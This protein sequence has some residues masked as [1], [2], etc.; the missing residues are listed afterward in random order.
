MDILDDDLIRLWKAL[1]NHDVRYMMVGGFAAI[2]HGT[3]RITQDAD[4]WI[5]DTLQNRQ[6]FRKAL[7]AADVGDYE[8]LETMDFVPGFTTIYLNQYIE[9]DLFTDL[10]FFTSKRFDECYSN[11]ETAMIENIPVK[12]LSLQHLIEE[13][14][15]ADRPKDLLD[16]EELE[17]IKKLNKES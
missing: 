2:F 10:K 12:F 14:K 7:K 13:K 5:E 11:A 9:L 16:I 4:I 3:S 6:A 17:K 15:A 8:M 1:H